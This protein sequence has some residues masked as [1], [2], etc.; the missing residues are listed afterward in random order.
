MNVS[1]IIK[2]CQQYDKKYQLEL[3]KTFS[4]MLKTVC[5]TYAPDDATAKDILQEAFIIIFTKIDTYKPIGSFEGWMRRIT[6]NCALNWLRKSKLVNK[7]NMQALREDCIEPRIYHDL[8]KEDVIKILQNLPEIQR[9]VFSLNVL[10][11]YSHKEIAEELN[12][13]EATSRSHFLRA[14]RKLQEKIKLQQIKLSR[15][16]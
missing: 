12:I 9:A 11:G 5:R 3:V 10:E 6:V 7:T 14:R 8:S 2:G 13:K 15:A 16:I 1:E 4:G